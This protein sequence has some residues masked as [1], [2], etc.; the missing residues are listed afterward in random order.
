MNE[1]KILIEPG[2]VEIKTT[3]E[4]DDLVM[5]YLIEAIY[6]IRNKQYEQFKNSTKVD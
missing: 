1:I 6:K 3:L 4:H 2:K 5:F